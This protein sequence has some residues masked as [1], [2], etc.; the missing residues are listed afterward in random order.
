MMVLIGVLILVIG[1][2]IANRTVTLI[3]AV[4]AIIGL[5]LLVTAI[6]GPVVGH[7]Y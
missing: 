2:V 3:G 4:I 5:L 7:W 1:L 6:P